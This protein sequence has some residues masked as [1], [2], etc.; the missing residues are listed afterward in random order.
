MAITIPLLKLKGLI[1]SL[2]DYIREDLSTCIS[3]DREDE[4]F[5]SLVLEGNESDNYNFYTQA[6]AVFSRTAES[7]QKITTGIAFP[8]DAS[9]LPYVWIR[10]PQRQK[11]KTNGIGK[12]M[13]VDVMFGNVEEGESQVNYRN[14]FRD[15]KQSSY[16]VVVVSANY[17]ESIM[18][19]EVL[20]SMLLGSYDLLADLYNLAEVNMKEIMMNNDSIPPYSFLSRALVIDIDFENYIPTVSAGQLISKINFN[21]VI[22]SE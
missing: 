18:I 12:S 7:R 5:L 22:K 19:S 11:G 4:S 1:D 13:G 8:K 17:M 16:E 6:K 14:Q 3:E 21:N 15:D 9:V 20:Y 10:E 2:L